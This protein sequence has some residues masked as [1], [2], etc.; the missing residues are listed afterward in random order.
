[1]TRPAPQADPPRHALIVIGILLALITIPELVVSAADQG[2]IGSPRWRALSV[3]YGAFWPGL[4]D[5]WQPNYAAQ[6][7]AMFLSYS[8]LHG[9]LVHLIG[10][11]A[12]LIWIGPLVI[13]RLGVSGFLWVW[14]LS[15]LAGAAAFALLTKGTTPMVGASGSVF[16]LS[17]AAVALQYILPRRYLTAIGVSL[18]LVALNVMSLIIENGFLAWQ[19]HLGG[20]ICGAAV[21]MVRLAGI[22]HFETRSD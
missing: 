15:A 22:R 7:W 14:V 11:A 18:G 17:G 2:L 5:N 8:F 19:P 13:R 1:M 3:Q 4:L 6:P 16:G 9:G 10:N 20:Y 12:M 21:A